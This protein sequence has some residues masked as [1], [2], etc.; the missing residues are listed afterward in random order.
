MFQ[1]LNFHHLFCYLIINWFTLDLNFCKQTFQGMKFRALLKERMQV[2]SWKD[3]KV[4]K[5][6]KEGEVVKEEKR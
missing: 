3:G 1:V 2:K 6:E 5:R 4:V